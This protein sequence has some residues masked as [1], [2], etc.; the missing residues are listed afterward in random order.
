MMLLYTL[1]PL[2]VSMIEKELAA[3]SLLLVSENWHNLLLLCINNIEYKNHALV[4]H[5]DA[6]IMY[7]T[8]VI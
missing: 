1:H 5:T 6:R 7:L 2:F 4:K 3:M 8:N